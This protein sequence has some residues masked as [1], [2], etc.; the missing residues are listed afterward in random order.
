MINDFCH[1]DVIKFDSV[2][3]DIAAQMRHYLHVMLYNFCLLAP[4]GF[5]FVQQ[6]LVRSKFLYTKNYYTD[7]IRNLYF[8]GITVPFEFHEIRIHWGIA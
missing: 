2:F 7:L 1:S 8:G 3:P 5:K 4:F 6:T